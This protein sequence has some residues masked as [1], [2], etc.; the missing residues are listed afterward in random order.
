[1]ARI[2][3]RAFNPFSRIVFGNKRKLFMAMIG[4]RASNLDSLLTRARIGRRVLNQGS[5]PRIIFGNK[6]IFSRIVKRAFNQDSVPTMNS[7]LTRARIGERTLNQDYL[8][9]IVFGN[10]RPFLNSLGQKITNTVNPEADEMGGHWMF[11][12]RWT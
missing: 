8:P 3:K 4:K 9:R 1:M 12:Q 6:R 5:L 11:P 7:L 10:R 2:G